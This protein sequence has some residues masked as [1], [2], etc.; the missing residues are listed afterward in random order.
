MLASDG[1]RRVR[2]KVDTPNAPRTTN[3]FLCSA[4][5]LALYDPRGS[6][7]NCLLGGTWHCNNDDED[8]DDAVTNS[9]YWMINDCIE[10]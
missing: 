4:V 7:S 10:D 5:Q 8:D 3:G 2:E 1:V 6:L 9:S